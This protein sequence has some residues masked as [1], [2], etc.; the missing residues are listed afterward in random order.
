[1]THVAVADVEVE[2]EGEKVQL[3]AG[4]SYLDSEHDIVRAHPQFFAPTRENLMRSVSPGTP[5][6][7]AEREQA[8]KE[9]AAREDAIRSGLE[10]GHVEDGAAA[11]D[12]KTLTRQRTSSPQ[13]KARSEALRTLEANDRHLS[14]RAGDRLTNVIDADEFGAD[15]AYITAVANDA[16]RTAFGKLLADPIGGRNRLTDDEVAAVQ[17][18]NRAERLRALS[19]SGNAGA[20]GGLAVPF[21]LDPTIILTD[22]GSVSPWRELANVVTLSNSFTWQ[23][24]SSEGVYA[25]FSGPGSG[26]QPEATEADD[27]APSFDQPE[28]K[29]E[30]AQA[31][32]PFS[33][34]VGQ[35]FGSLQSQ[36]ARLL[37][38]AKSQLE[39]EKFTRGSGTDEPE[40][41]LTGL[42]AQTFDTD[43]ASLVP[44]DLYAV[45]EDLGPRF[46]A[47]ASWVEPL[48][49]ANQVRRFI[50]TDEPQL[51]NDAYTAQ[52]GQPLRLA[53]TIVKPATTGDVVAVYGNVREAYTV[54]DRIGFSVELIPHLFGSNNRPTGQ[55]GLYAYWRVGA[56]V[57]NPNA[58]RVLVL[59][60]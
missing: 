35:D 23:G 45:Q 33:I 40:G 59:G 2:Y 44:S 37:Q 5:K 24:V 21:V 17:E 20:D 3:T 1:M 31:F 30:K 29:A 52:L 16:Y 43:G 49:V 11:H 36:L 15:R 12:D 55:R 27:N 10:A 50:D 42:S 60:S 18:V 25:S 46:V 13:D 48:S 14:A 54:V 7:D 19:I 38:D 6:T 26:F 9:R 56:A 32:V 53:S 8:E 57:V 51:V 34:E 28:I 4:R 39:D 47:G 58:A 41:I 22:D